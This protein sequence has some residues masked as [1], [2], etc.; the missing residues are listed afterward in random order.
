MSNDNGEVSKNGDVAWDEIEKEIT[1]MECL[2][3]RLPEEERAD[4]AARFVSAAA[5]QAGNNFYETLGIFEEAKFQFREMWE[6]AMERED[7]GNNT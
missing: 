2:L 7:D 6:E 1:L 4:V 5:I 3:K